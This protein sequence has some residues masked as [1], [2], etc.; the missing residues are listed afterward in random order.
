[1]KVD[2]LTKVEFKKVKMGKM[3][4]FLSESIGLH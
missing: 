4:E 3:V 2:H 1:M